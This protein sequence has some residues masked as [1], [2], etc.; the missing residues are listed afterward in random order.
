M[1]WTNSIG[2][3]HISACI[4]NNPY[5]SCYFNIFQATEDYTILLA[6]RFRR[7]DSQSQLAP[8]V[9]QR[10]KTSPGLLQTVTGKLYTFLTKPNKSFT[11]CRRLV[12]Y[13]ACTAMLLNWKPYSWMVDQ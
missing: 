5:Y 7:K 11:G 4:A 8:P 1:C 6:R 2:L 13:K 12:I 3:Y 9:P 10:V